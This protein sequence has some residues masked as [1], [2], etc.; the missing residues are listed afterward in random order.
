M[1][2]SPRVTDEMKS[3][4]EGL[5]QVAAPLALLFEDSDLYE[6]QIQPTGAVYGLE[7][8]GGIRDG[9]VEMGV[10]D[11][12]LF[13]SF[14]ANA[15]NARFD[16]SRDYFLACQLPEM[17]PFRRARLHA[18]LPIVASGTLVCIRKHPERSYSLDADYL[19][20]EILSASQV[21]FLRERMAVA[22]SNLLIVGS[23]GSGKTQLANALLSDVGIRFPQ[24]RIGI[25]EDVP[26]IVLPT[27]R[28]FRLETA[29]LP[30]PRDR[31]QAGQQLV[32]LTDQ[33]PHCL[34][35]TPESLV[36]G[37]LRLESAAKALLE[38]WETGHP[39]GLTTIHAGT[40]HQGLTRLR[41]LALGDGQEFDVET[42]IGDAIDTVVHI[43]RLRQQ[44]GAKTARFR[45]TVHTLKVRDR[46]FELEEVA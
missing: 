24:R 12:A 40:A 6:I 30:P 27:R 42:R 15:C 4:L 31:P 18:M 7:V 46:S 19:Q 8:G 9:E 39:G 17:A 34:R 11:L 41:N 5:R 20:R 3:A 28:S 21:A 1:G 26:E 36:L 44:A 25:V 45:A 13:L 16:E 22:A 38:A 14:A 23:T 2:A 43:R 10:G 29:I 33:I 35:L 37:E 32:T